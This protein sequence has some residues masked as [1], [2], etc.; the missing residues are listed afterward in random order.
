[1]QVQDLV[2]VLESRDVARP[3]CA[4]MAARIRFPYPQPPTDRPQTVRYGILG[5]QTAWSSLRRNTLVFTAIG[6]F[7]L[8]AVEEV[9]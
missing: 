9:L 6:T 8:I 5:T 4:C 1:L 3:P 7:L 2:A